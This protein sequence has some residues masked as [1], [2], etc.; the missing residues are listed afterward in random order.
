MCADTYNVERHIFLEGCR[1]SNKPACQEL[2]CPDYYTGDQV[3]AQQLLNLKCSFSVH[4]AS[5]LAYGGS[6]GLVRPP[7]QLVISGDE[8][9]CSI[10]EMQQRLRL[11]ARS[12][13]AH[14]AKW[15]RQCA[16]SQQQAA[17]IAEMQSSLQAV[18]EERGQLVLQA[19][20]ALVAAEQR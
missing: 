5:A 12:G 13:A 2:R 7:S 18:E 17:R 15:R 4:R 10:H 20:E 14:L 8:L 16:L 6:L 11:A 19:H 3:S 9:A 1:A